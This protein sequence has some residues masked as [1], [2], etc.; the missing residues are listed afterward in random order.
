[1]RLFT[2]RSSRAY[3][4]SRLELP[5][6]T[7]ADRASM[8]LVVLAAVFG[9]YAALRQGMSPLAVC[10]VFVG[11]LVSFAQANL[12][13]SARRRPCR[14]LECAPDGTLRLHQAG[15]AP[16][17]VRLGA[18][19]RLLGATLVMEIRCGDTAGAERCRWWLT[20]LDVPREALRR[21]TIVLL[22]TGRVART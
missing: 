4:T 5:A 10:W 19:T 6:V 9:A 1:M 21:W 16:T 22:A 3:G 2:V 11:M 14:W 7:V 20:P 8:M 15:M 18:S 13:R 12:W 17:P